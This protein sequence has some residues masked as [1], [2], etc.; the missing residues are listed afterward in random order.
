MS[1]PQKRPQSASARRVANYRQRMRDAG[2]VPKT[3]WV[4]DTK[5]PEYAAEARR[6]SIAVAAHDPGGDE[7]MVWLD[8]VR[9]WPEE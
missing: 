4:H 3:I 1:T 6:Q 5:S 7:V 8:D 2:Y 9:A